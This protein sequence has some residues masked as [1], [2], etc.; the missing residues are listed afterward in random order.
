MAKAPKVNKNRLDMEEVFDHEH[1]LS[2]KLMFNKTL[3]VFR[4][5]NAQ[6]FPPSPQNGQNVESRYEDSRASIVSVVEKAMHIFFKNPPR[7]ESLKDQHHIL[8]QFIAVVCL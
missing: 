7:T 4:S 6:S 8:F 3:C 2:E 1:E 5:D